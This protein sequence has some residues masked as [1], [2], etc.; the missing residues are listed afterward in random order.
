MHICTTLRWPS[1][2]HRLQRVTHSAESRHTPV[3]RFTITASPAEAVAVGAC[4]WLSKL[5]ALRHGHR[6]QQSAPLLLA[7][8]HEHCADVICMYNLSMLG[9]LL[10]GW[11]RRPQ[12]RRTLQSTPCGHACAPCRRPCREFTSSG[13]RAHSPADTSCHVQIMYGPV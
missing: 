7:P 1:A 3:R 4:F 11:T 8:D 9:I 10:Q 12:S 13:T 5:R 6:W 2:Y